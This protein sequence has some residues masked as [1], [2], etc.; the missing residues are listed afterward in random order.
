MY[1]MSTGTSDHPDHADLCSAGCGQHRKP[2]FIF[3]GAWSGRDF[4][5]VPGVNML[6]A[7]RGDHSLTWDANRLVKRWREVII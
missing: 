5:F 1:V 2:H 6:L 3:I 7:G 4:H